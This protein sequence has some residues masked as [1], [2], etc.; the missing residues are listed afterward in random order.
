MTGFIKPGCADTNKSFYILSAIYGFDGLILLFKYVSN[1]NEFVG[2]VVLG[3]SI[4]LM[5]INNAFPFYVYCNN[6][7]FI[8]KTLPF[9]YKS[10]LTILIELTVTSFILLVFI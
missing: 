3:N 10:L 2:I 6:A 5:S 7:F 8:N 9:I 4:F 1:M